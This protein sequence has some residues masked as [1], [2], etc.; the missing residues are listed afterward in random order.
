MFE[1]RRQVCNSKKKGLEYL[2]D[3]LG[4]GLERSGGGDGV[5]HADGERPVERP[6]VDHHLAAVHE[7]AV[8]VRAVLEVDEMDQRA[9]VLPHGLVVDDAMQQLAVMDQ[10]LWIECCGLL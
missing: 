6:V 4:D 3:V 2:F 5:L 9:R 1:G 7:V 10:H 8:R